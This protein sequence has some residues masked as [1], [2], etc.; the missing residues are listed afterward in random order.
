MDIDGE[1]SFEK[2]SNIKFYCGFFGVEIDF[3]VEVDCVKIICIVG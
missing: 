1:V 3:G 2:R